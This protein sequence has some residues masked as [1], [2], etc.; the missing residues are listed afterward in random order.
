[1]LTPCCAIGPV[2]K[3][4]SRSMDDSPCPLPPAQIAKDRF[5]SFCLGTPT[6]LRVGHDAA[7][8]VA[9]SGLAFRKETGGACRFCLRR[10]TRSLDGAFSFR[11]LDKK[12]NRLA[13][14]RK[15]L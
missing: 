4:W 7:T 6:M 15:E 2:T 9:V 10:K 1:M 12:P 8:G 11:K 3:Y 13:N 5:C 14:P